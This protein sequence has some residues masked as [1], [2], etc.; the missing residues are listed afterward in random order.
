MNALLQRGVMAQ[1]ERR[2]DA[3]AVVCQSGRL[4]YRELDRASTQLAKLLRGRWD[5][6]EEIACVC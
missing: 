2:G 5:A 3:T 4:T 6:S 1:A